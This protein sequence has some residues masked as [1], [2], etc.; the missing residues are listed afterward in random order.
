S[1]GGIMIECR[2]V[3]DRLTGRKVRWN[4]EYDGAPFELYIP[5]WRVPD[6]IPNV[7][8]V[9]IEAASHPADGS[10]SP[11]ERPPS[12]GAS[13]TPIVAL[14][15]KVREHTK[16]VRYRPRGLPDDWEIGEP[17]VPQGVLADVGSAGDWPATLRI[18]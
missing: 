14:V 16:T 18:T 17:Y 10:V 8:Y 4:A 3:T 5:Q 6:P 15:D 9:D 11:S 2:L 12:Q 13:G 1:G 7:I